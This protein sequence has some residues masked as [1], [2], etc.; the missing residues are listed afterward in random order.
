MAIVLLG[1]DMKYA[2]TRWLQTLLPV[3]AKELIVHL[4]FHVAPDQFSEFTHTYC[5][6]PSMEN[7]LSGLLRR[8]FVPET[9]IDVGAYEGAWTMAAKRVW[10]ASRIIMI[11]ANR[12]KIAKLTILG[13]AKCEL[14]G[15]ENGKVVE[16]SVMETGSSIFDENSSV[17]R[18]KER[19]QLSTLDSL[20]L[21]ISRPA[22]LKIDAQGYELEILKGATASMPLME[23][24]LLEVALIEI[25]RG[26]PLIHEVFSFM[27]RVGFLAYDIFEMHRRPLDGA[28]SQVDVLFVRKDSHLRQNSSFEL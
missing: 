18:V 20:D 22:L 14:L 10:P 25:N 3:R 2:F 11:E 19:R 13:E 23:A 27:E 17:Q 8:E 12:E 7:G 5:L 28:L 16:F 6:A 15:S 24:I 21:N 1:E 9:I 4:G 26:A